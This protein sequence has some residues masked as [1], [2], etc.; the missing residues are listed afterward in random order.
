MKRAGI[1]ALVVLGGVI[2][3]WN[4]LAGFCGLP[5]LRYSNACGHNAFV[6]L[7]A[8]IAGGVLLCWLAIG[9]PLWNWPVLHRRARLALMA[10]FLFVAIA[11]VGSVLWNRTRTPEVAAVED[12]TAV[13]MAILKGFRGDVVYVGSQQDYAYFRTD[14][15][16]CSNYKVPATL[17]RLPRSFPIDGGEPYV[18]T[19]EVMGY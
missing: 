5:G 12:V 16:F 11:F 10:F 8:T 2:L 3:G 4:F 18:A 6:L 14:Y 13:R 17:V 7:P 1:I 15:I 9:R 19:W